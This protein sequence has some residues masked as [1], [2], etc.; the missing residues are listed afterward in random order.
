MLGDAIL[1][2]KRDSEYVPA[3]EICEYSF[4]IETTGQY[5]CKYKNKLS[6][7]SPDNCCSHFSLDLLSIEPHSRRAKE[8]EFAQI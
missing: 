3:C 6:S 8:L 4:C 1:K 5:L 2:L 7:T